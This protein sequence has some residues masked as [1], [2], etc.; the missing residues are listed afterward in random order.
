MTDQQ[1]PI[2][3][4]DFTP[5]LP[6]FRTA[7]FLELTEALL[8]VPIVHDPA[9][10]NAAPFRLETPEPLPEDPLPVLEPRWYPRPV[11]AVTDA[12]RESLVPPPRPPALLGRSDAQERILR[13]L[14]S[15]H[16]VRVC[17]EAGVGKTTLLAALANHQ[18]TRQRFRRVWWIDRPARLDQ[19]LALALNMPHVLAEPDP[20]ARRGWLRDRLDEHTLLIVDN[21][22]PGDTILDDLIDLTPHVLAA[23]ETA[24]QIPDPDEPVPDDPEGVITLRALDDTAAVDALAVFAAIEDTRQMRG[25]L[26]RVAHMLGNHPY[27]LML[28]GQIMRRDG[29]TLDELERVLVLEQDNADSDTDDSPGGPDDLPPDAASDEAFMSGSDESAASLNRALD[30]SVDALPGDYRRLF[31]AFGAFPPDGAPFEGLRA[32]SRV[33]SA[34]ACRRGLTALIDY[35]LVQRDHRD[36]A[37]YIMHPVAYARAAVIDHHAGRR[38]T[39]KHMRAWALRLARSYTPEEADENDSAEDCALALYRAET[40]LFYARDMADQHG[41]KTQYAALCD[42]LRDYVRDY[43]PGGLPP[44]DAGGNPPVDDAPPVL[45]GPRAEAANLTHYGLELTA[46]GAAYAAEEALNRALAIRRTHDS[47]HAVSETLVALA[48]LY[49]LNGRHT[50]AAEAL[51]EAAELLYNLGAEPSLSVVRRGLARVYRHMGRLNDALDVL[52]DAPEAHLERAITLRDQGSF[53]AAVTEMARAEHASGYLRAETFVL[54]GAYADALDA[55]K[56]Q[57]DPASASLRAQIVHLQGYTDQAIQGYKLALAGFEAENADT[58]GPDDHRAARAKILRG[59]GAALASSGQRDAA[60]D[61]LDEALA[62]ERAGSPPDPL[63]LGRTLRLIAA[64]ILVGGDASGAAETA[65][66]AL[67][68]LGQVE[69]PG[70]CADAYRT[71]GRALWAMDD[72][73]GARDAF[74]SEVEHAQA[75]PDRDENRIGVALH[76][77]ADLYRLTD[78]VDRAIANYRRALTHKNPAGDP[79]GYLVTQLAMHRALMEGG[80]FAAA[81]DVTQEILDHLSRQPQ[82]DLLQIGFAQTVR[83][84]TQ[85]TMQRPIRATQSTAEWTRVLVVR[86]DEAANDPRPAI[87]V[88]ALGLAVRSLLAEGQAGAVIDA[89]E[90]A[91]FTAD[92]FFPD[93]LAAWAARRDL[94]AVYMALDRSEDAILTLDPLLAPGVPVDRPTRALAHD[95]T[96]TG[97]R[98]LG[99]LSQVLEHFQAALVDEPDEH[100]QGRLH[101][102]CGDVL[103]ELGQPSDAITSY[104]AALDLIDRGDYPDVAARILTTLAHTLGGLN[105]YAEAIGVYEDALVMLREVRGVSATHTADVLSH[106]GQTH[107]SQGQLAEAARVY[108]R[109]LNVLERAEAPRQQQDIL[110]RLA[111]V[112]AAL[113]DDQEAV[114]L[115][116]QTCDHVREWGDDRELG[117]VL[118]EL[119]DLHRDAGR[120]APAIRRYEEALACQSAP[121]FIRERANTLR[122]LG[123]AYAQLERYDDARTAWTEALDISRELPDQS[124]LEIALT[125]HAIAEAFRS[126][127][128]TAEAERTFREALR[129]HTPGTVP[130]AATWRALGETLHA[131]GRHDEAVKPLENALSAEKAQSQQSNA[132]LVKTLQML[133]VVH[134]ARGDR[135]ASITRYHESLV[136]MDQNLQPIACA[137]TLR[138]LGRLY[139]ENGESESAHKALGD[140]LAIESDFAPRSD[141]RISATLQAIAD[142]HRAAGDLE[143]AAAFYQKVTVY[144]NL[145]RR[146]SEDLRDTLDELERRRAT[147]QAAQQSLALLD[148]SDDAALK[149]QAFIYAL[150]ARTYAGLSQPEQSADTIRGLLDVLQ[151]RLDDLDPN[152]PE[153]DCQALAWL[154]AAVRAQDDSDIQA[155]QLACG[156]ALNAVQ[157]PNLLWVIEQVTRSLEDGASS[158]DEVLPEGEVS[159][160]DE[161]PPENAPPE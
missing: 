120:I 136:Y 23:L 108:R 39:G 65:R 49:D 160:E 123:R 117:E 158:E 56:D 74:T 10:L 82:P 153:P 124:P 106:L 126:Q 75:M 152:D 61:A 150:I 58:P 159:S 67:G 137:D 154:A 149:D 148:R 86:A 87:R 54:A 115:Y 22:M 48:R 144:A 33:G 99:D 76:H 68:Y 113:G 84:R 12:A 15:G 78:S 139:R 47:G 135:S 16:P 38:A 25:Q 70:D 133:A 94:G 116:E 60:R 20:A 64:V 105:R 13:P 27:A 138:T 77:L 32:A 53:D 89:A 59:L 101:E 44:D 90:R 30:V 63:R 52:D 143:K 96:G 156:A 18:R 155:A 97:Y 69:A 122:N 85:Q 92:R 145:A 66:E 81:L 130:A 140:A 142:T 24:P 119:A 29:L 62:C 57:D 34:L 132:R 72:L 112:T 95:L 109:A 17:G 31:E 14:L 41:S 8:D 100:R 1:D 2:T 125:Y 37:R 131:A 5:A 151:S 45:S 21:V 11:Q 147:L 121:F 50:Q 26:L 141:D 107:E 83:A 73:N 146:A 36:P 103:L 3:L 104:R 102:A 6:G 134:E 80:R 118:C 19:T 46:Q 157:N 71:L 55:I 110:H 129:H 9:R 127:D 42:A 128:H 43:V 111:R 93:T 91:L 51:L 35:G 114:T 28:A 40:S 4:P 7:E 79:H 98:Q 161:A 88:L